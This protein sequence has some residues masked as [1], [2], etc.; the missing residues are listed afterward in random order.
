MA[1]ILVVGLNP[2]WQK[3]YRFNHLKMAEVNR[4]VETQEFASG[5]GFNTAKVLKRLGHDVSLLQIL[6][7]N[8][9]ELC[10]KACAAEGIK[11]LHV[12]VARETR[13]CVTLLD[14]RGQA[15]ELIEPFTVPEDDWSALLTT[16]LPNRNET[17]GSDAKS[18]SFTGLVFCGSVP[19]GCPPWVFMDILESVNAKVILLD[20]YREL[21]NDFLQEMTCL[22]INRMEW[23]ELNK[24]MEQGWDKVGPP[25]LVTEGPKPA[26]LWEEG[27]P[28][29]QFI[30]PAA[31]PLQNP[32]GAGDTVTAG[33]LHFLL[34]GESLCDASKQALAMGVAS[35]QSLLPGDFSSIDFEHILSKTVHK[36][37]V[38]GN[39]AG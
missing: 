35:C 34:C 20:G 14:S 33:L 9:G 3:I 11:S 8:A 21:E 10:L 22:K 23:D 4:A 18:Q 16:L 5:K 39:Q 12:K 17:G 26:I 37:I 15:T 1:V 31:M 13:T 7:G 19:E 25:V 36:E 29:W 27:G 24:N 28:R 6:G 2:A 38:I 32:I 30:L